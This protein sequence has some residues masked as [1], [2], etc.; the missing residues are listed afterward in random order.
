MPDT[1]KPDS[2]KGDGARNAQQRRGR[3]AA[4]YLPMR[5][6]L[7]HFA[8][9]LRTEAFAT[10]PGMILWGARARGPAVPPGRY[11]VRL[12]ADGRTLTAPVIVKRNHWFAN[13][14]DADLRAQ[15]AFSKKVRDKTDEANEA[16]IAIRQVKKQLED[17]A[18][19]TDDSRLESSMTAL[20]KK[21]SAVEEK[22]YQV[23]NRS[24]QDPLNFPIKVN[25]RLATLLSMAERGDGRPTSNMPEIYGI[26]AKELD[27]YTTEL[28]RLW[29]SDLVSV[30]R[31]LSDAGLL[32]VDPKCAKAE[33]CQV[34]E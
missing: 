29:K 5:A 22:I 17:R 1:S 12:V 6:G 8:W 20:E 3:N 9:D 11:T 30:N 27:G 24:G 10:V 15:Y 26:L 7:S 18:K 23:R 33:G 32:P 16:V 34:V 14:S 2:T 25:N 31:G 13:V 21:A 28:S 19:R 4:A